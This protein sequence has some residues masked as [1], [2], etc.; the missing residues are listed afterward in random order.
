MTDSS[1]HTNETNQKDEA[2]HL[3]LVDDEEAFLHMTAAILRRA[4][5][6]C[7]C[8]QN[9][10]LAQELL[11]DGDYDLLIADIHMP[12]NAELEL[13]RNLPQ[14]AEGIP[15]ILVTGYPSFGS[16]VQSVRLPVVAYLVKPFTNDELISQVRLAVERGQLRRTIL[17]MKQRLQDWRH[18]LD[19]LADAASGVSSLPSAST[20][21]T[22]QLLTLRNI[23][24]TL[25]DLRLLPSPSAK[26]PSLPKS[27][28]PLSRREQEILQSLLTHHRVSLIAR[29]LHISPYTVRNHLK[30]IFRKLGVH[31]QSELLE[32]LQQTASS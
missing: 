4:G 10:T 16:A 19:Q 32:Q 24:G 18:N 8:A 28:V 1:Q 25:R 3:L 23:A 13:V 14:R 6:T 7:A 11:H 12:G 29:Y 5:Y 17:Q 21:E 20:A 31:S 30:S 2:R 27:A 22:L 9:T 26:E 15:V